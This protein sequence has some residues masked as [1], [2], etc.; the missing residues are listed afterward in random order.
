MTFFREDYRNAESARLKTPG[1]AAEN[2][3]SNVV[4]TV[5]KIY[6]DE[7]WNA[8]VLGKL[9]ESIQSHH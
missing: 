5:P 9:M 7:D 2:L 6:P 4:E 8:T 1:I 3:G